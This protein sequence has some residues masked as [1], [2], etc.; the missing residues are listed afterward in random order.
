[1]P[2][3]CQ[4]WGK[5]PCSCALASKGCTGKATKLSNQVGRLAVATRGQEIAGPQAT[6][7]T[8]LSS[9]AMPPSPGCDLLRQRLEPSQRH[10]NYRS[11]APRPPWP[12]RIGNVAV[13]DRWLNLASS[14]WRDRGRTP[15]RTDRG[16]LPRAQRIY[17]GQFPRQTIRPPH[18]ARPREPRG[19]GFLRGPHAAVPQSG[20]SGSNRMLPRNATETQETPPEIM[21]TWI[22]HRRP[23][24]NG[25]QP[26]PKKIPDSPEHR[27]HV[28]QIP[29]GAA[30]LRGSQVSSS[31]EMGLAPFF[32]TTTTKSIR[33][34]A[35]S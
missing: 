3:C 31:L 9:G 19:L 5:V 12:G 20:L 23:G 13:S 35:A 7:V 27:R 24:S 2:Y 6:R 16:C 26:C 8:A 11:V 10:G 21:D 22:P 29:P 30:R 1:L 14:F 28:P 4:S 15:K 33:L 32:A 25:S 17:I 18:D 34:S